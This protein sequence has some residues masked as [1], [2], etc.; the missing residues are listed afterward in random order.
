MITTE[1]QSLDQRWQEYQRLDHIRSHWYWRPGWRVG[2]SFYTWHLTF[3]D[4][5]DLHQLTA[6][7]ERDLDL[8]C[9]DRVPLEG[10]HLTMQGLGFADEVSD[11]DVEAIVDAARSQ[12][13]SLS[14]FDL[15]LGPVDPD[16]EG[17]GLLVSPWH[18]VVELRS[19][20]RC[21]ISQVWDDVPE[22]GSGFRPHVTVAY[23]NADAPAE[24][25]RELLDPLRLT[26]PV[27]AHVAM[28]QLIRLNRDEKVYRWDVAASVPLGPV[29]NSVP[30]PSHPDEGPKAHLDHLTSWR[31]S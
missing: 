22:S 19:A 4:A 3:E 1:Q 31:A 16:A 23:S 12:L 20:I 29:Q 27:S 18:A 17:I 7:L 14:P 26:P 15:S 11:R 25:V 9:L 13:R 10:L 5:T 28:A 24:P 21:A 30:S 2:R 8:D 6:T